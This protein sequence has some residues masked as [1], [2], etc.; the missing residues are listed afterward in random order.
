MTLNPEALLPEAVVARVEVMERK[1][2][3]QDKIIESLQSENNTLKV[4]M[5]KLLTQ[6]PPSAPSMDDLEVYDKGDTS[7]I[8]EGDDNDG[9]AASVIAA[10]E[11]ADAASSIVATS[12]VD[13]VSQLAEAKVIAVKDNVAQNGISVS[14]AP[15]TGSDVAATSSGK[16]KVSMKHKRN[17]DAQ[18]IA[19]TA[20]A[21]AAQSGLSV[22]DAIKVGEDTASTGSS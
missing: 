3:A 1:V 15:A 8:V 22:E 13:G 2:N 9:E 18:N 19:A 20:A 10:D 5:Q 16:M 7:S 12:S 4:E 11:A 21:H 17:I 14:S 6:Q